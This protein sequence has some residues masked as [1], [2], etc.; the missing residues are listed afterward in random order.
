MAKL[1]VS[2]I[3]YKNKSRR[4]VS[5]ITKFSNPYDYDN[6]SRLEMRGTRHRT[7]A[8]RHSGYITGDCRKR[9]RERFSLYD[10]RFRFKQTNGAYT[11]SESKGSRINILNDLNPCVKLSFVNQFQG[12]DV[13]RAHAKLIRQMVK[14]RC[15]NYFT[16]VESASLPVRCRFILFTSPTHNFFT[17]SSSQGL[18]DNVYRCVQSINTVY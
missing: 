3:F 16:T 10:F 2:Q 11:Q 14:W 4:T 9:S 5:I 1:F 13:S 12:Q 8:N 15:V 17:E 18:M 7:R 6:G